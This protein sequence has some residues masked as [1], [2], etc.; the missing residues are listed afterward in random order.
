MCAR[1]Q[2]APDPGNRVGS[3]RFEGDDYGDVTSTGV[4]PK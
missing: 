1:A 2:Y 4:P 3:G